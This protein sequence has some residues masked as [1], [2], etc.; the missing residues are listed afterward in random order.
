MMMVDLCVLIVHR[1]ELMTRES[2]KR[3]FALQGKIG[4]AIKLVK[5]CYWREYFL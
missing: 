1:E 2:I 5:L 4:I 3:S